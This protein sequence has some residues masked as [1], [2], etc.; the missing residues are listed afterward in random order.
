MVSTCVCEYN[1][2]LSRGLPFRNASKQLRK[3]VMPMTLERHI[4]ETA[5]HILLA[6]R[7]TENSTFYIQQRTKY[8]RA[9]LP[10]VGLPLLHTILLSL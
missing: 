10:F 4:Y 9:L 5:V 2:V 6:V 8:Y 1:V 7:C 3:T